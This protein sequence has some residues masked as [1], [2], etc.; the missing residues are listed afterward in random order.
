LT[1]E[2]ELNAE[3]NK[4]LFD[5][6]QRAFVRDRRPA[7]KV[8]HGSFSYLRR[9]CHFLLGKAQPSPSGSELLFVNHKTVLLMC[10]MPIVVCFVR[11]R[12]NR[13]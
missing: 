6:S 10:H 3:G 9:P 11:E 12:D 7:L 1:F 5:V 13:G 4:R 8:R 2:L